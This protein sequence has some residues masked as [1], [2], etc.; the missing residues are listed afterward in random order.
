MPEAYDVAVRLDA[1]WLELP[2]QQQVDVSQ[3]AEQLVSD[4]AAARE[5]EPSTDRRRVYEQTYAALLESTCA[6]TDDSQQLLAAYCLVPGEEL[7]YTATAQLTAVS[8]ATGMTQE[9]VVSE[10]VVPEGERYGPPVVD[11]LDTG[12][13]TCTRVRQLLLAE[14]GGDDES[15]VWTSLAYAWPTEDDG[16]YLLL[17]ASFASPVDAAVHEADVDALAQSLTLQPLA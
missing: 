3:W 8:L 1:R 5:V 10:L 9:D 14:P 13:G 4:A 6:P 7:L 16:I 12:F 11:E 2:V 17:T 15:G